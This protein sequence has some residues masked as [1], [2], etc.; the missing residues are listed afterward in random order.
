MPSEGQMC[1]ERRGI[2]EQYE[3]PYRVG[4]TLPDH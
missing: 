2:L 1:A 4:F 3:N